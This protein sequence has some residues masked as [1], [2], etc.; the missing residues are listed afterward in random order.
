MSHFKVTTN[1]DGRRSFGEHDDRWTD[2]GR[3]GHGGGQRTFGKRGGRKSYGGFNRGS[4]YNRGG[5]PDRSRGRGRGF[6]QG[7][8]PR[9]R[10][11]DEGDVDMGGNSGGP[12]T[13]RYTPYGNNRRGDRRKTYGRD[14]DTQASSADKYKKMGLPVRGSDNQWYRVLIPFGKKAGKDGLLKL[15]NDN[16]DVP[17]IPV[18]FHFEQE[19][20]VF[21]IQDRQASESLRRLSNRLTMPN[22]FKMIVIA[23]PSG[24]PSV[25][26]LDEEGIEKLKV[27]MSSRYDPATKALNLSNLYN[28]ANLSQEKIHLALNKQTVMSQVS[29]IIGENI[30]ELETL[31]VSENK[32]MGL[33][34][35]R[36]LVSKAPNVVRLNIGKNLIRVIEELEKIKG[37]KLQEL[38]LDGNDLCDRF[39]DR[40]AYIS[41]VRKR[42]PKVIKLDGHD[43]PPPITF[44][45]ESSSSLPPK[46]GSFF[47]SPDLQELT[48]KFLKEYF[49]IYD[50]V[51]RQSLLPAYQDDALFSLSTAFNP[52][53]EYSQP[54]LHD[55]MPESRNLLK[56]S[57]DPGKRQKVLKKGKLG[58]VSQLCELPK[59]THDY[60]SFVVDVDHASSTL[61]SFTVL[62]VFKED[63]RSDKPPIR[64]FSRHFVT[65]PSGPGM[66]IV[67]D[68]LTVTNASHEQFQK[69]FKSQAPTPSSSP[70]PDEGPSV[71]FPPPACSTSFTPEQQQ[72]IQSF[73]HD[74]GMN[75]EWSAKCLQQYNWDYMEAGKVFSELQKQNKIPPEAFLS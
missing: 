70:V 34:N 67:N 56:M 75:A 69:A 63:S 10:F 19:K 4:G 30:P 66:V 42:F 22:G 62:G 25:F 43:L 21:H 23:K 49:T 37:W 13:S 29:D 16:L 11:D 54:K 14:R 73:C 32:L 45:L 55:Y 59:T 71:P 12:S 38:I 48:V 53:I 18:C 2:N 57:R 47:L 7:P 46:K 41:A 64:S 61:L 40:T 15:L 72:K 65:V 9:S 58:I 68:M 33:E 8:G 5:R 6:N 35:M 17:F 60:N 1:R 3:G 74:S 52:L 24:P 44:D 50:S 20:A 39:K 26:T 36:D 31:D 28:D 27:C 51:D